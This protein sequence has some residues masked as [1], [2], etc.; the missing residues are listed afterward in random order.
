MIK[1]VRAREQ[2]EILGIIQRHNRAVNFSQL[3]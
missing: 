3:L 1:L 2:E